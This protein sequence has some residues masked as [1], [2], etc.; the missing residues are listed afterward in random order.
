MGKVYTIYLKHEFRLDLSF[1]T[2]LFHSYQKLLV[3]IRLWDTNNN[4]SDVWN[5][6]MVSV[7]VTISYDD[8]YKNNVL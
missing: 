4:D 8:Q 1:A 5:A 7:A 6:S 3:L 2:E